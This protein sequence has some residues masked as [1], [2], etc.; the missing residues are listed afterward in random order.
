MQS[1][2]DFV[3]GPG[4]PT[5]AGRA[6]ARLHARLT[7]DEGAGPDGIRSV[8]VLDRVLDE[9]TAVHDALDAQYFAT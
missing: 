3:Q 6:I 9:I 4:E 2:L 5:P 1:Y 8:D 7:E